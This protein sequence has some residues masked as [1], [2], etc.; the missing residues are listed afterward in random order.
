MASFDVSYVIKAL[1]RFSGPAAKIK[2]N[3]AALDSTSS[4]LSETINKSGQSLTGVSSKVES[5]TGLTSQLIRHT[6][7]AGM[8]TDHILD[9][10]VAGSRHLLEASDKFAFKAFIQSM[11]IAMPLMLMFA[12]PFDDMVKTENA[13]STLQA[14]LGKLSAG[15]LIKQIDHLSETTGVAQSDLQAVA[16][17]L[18]FHGASAKLT[19]QL[20]K[21]IAEMSVATDKKAPQIAETFAKAIAQNSGKV[22][23]GGGIFIDAVG[24]SNRAAQIANMIKKKFGNLAEEI[25]KKPANQVKMAF[26]SMGDS[27]QKFLEAAAPALVTLAGIMKSLSD[28]VSKFAEKHKTAAK[29]IGI[30]TVV[31]LALVSAAV[32][33]GAVMNIVAFAAVGFSVGLKALKFALSLTNGELIITR[34]NMIAAKIETIAFGA[35]QVGAAIKVGAVRLALL[36]WNIVLKSFTVVTAIARGAMFA[37][38]LVMSANPIGLVIMA[39]AA[40]LGLLPLLFSNWKKIS[41]FLSSVF[42]PVI[43]RI[44]DGLW[45]LMH[46][47]EALQKGWDSI[48]GWFSKVFGGKTEVVAKKITDN[49]EVAKHLA[50]TT[51]T[52]NHTVA[53]PALI[54]SAHTNKSSVE[55]HMK[56]D[57]AGRNVKTVQTRTSHPNTIVNVGSTSMGIA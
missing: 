31:A 41:A 12:K 2:S 1:D 32:V 3:M 43:D 54:N 36:A 42:G 13:A 29:W 40:L 35:V 25:N 24:M 27:A 26:K 23:I 50:S 45:N 47:I 5:L 11:N 38:N 22:D 57:D 15:N 30:V 28:T 52:V 55:V 39:V 51:H 9:R 17:S 37:F 7:S 49:T 34:L 21:P 19:E 53:S 44:K 16:K 48:K 20:L 8:A 14:T 6:R 18:T 4:K 10:M 33:L 46:P 56:I